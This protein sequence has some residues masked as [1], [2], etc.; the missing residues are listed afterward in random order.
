VIDFVVSIQCSF[1]SGETGFTFNLYLS[2]GS[3]NFVVTTNPDL[4]SGSTF[5]N[6]SF[7]ND[8]DVAHL[9]SEF[10]AN[11]LK[12]IVTAD[13]G[14]AD[15]SYVHLTVHYGRMEVCGGGLDGIVCMMGWIL[16]TAIDGF[17]FIINGLIFI[18]S[19]MV[20]LVQ[21]AVSFFGIIGS[22]MSLPGVPTEIQTII[23]VV[24]IALVIMLVIAVFRI[25]RGSGS[26]G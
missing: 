7:R 6:Y 4:C 3:T 21:M 14:S 11:G 5:Q 16:N 12:L 24:L 19:A 25:V 15:I 13:S 17:L 18:G 2:N 1:P 23:N 10:D 22:A 20:W 8:L 26:T 9:V